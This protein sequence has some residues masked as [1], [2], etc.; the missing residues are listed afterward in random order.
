VGDV[1]EDHRAA[2]AV[3]VAALETVPRV[4]AGHEN[5]R[6]PRRKGVVAKCWPARRK[7]RAERGVPRTIGK[8]DQAGELF[9]AEVGVRCSQNPSTSCAYSSR[10]NVSSIARRSCRRSASR[11]RAPGKLRRRRASRETSPCGRVEIASLIVMQFALAET[12]S[13]TGG[14]KERPPVRRRRRRGTRLRANSVGKA[15]SKAAAP[16]RR[17]RSFRQCGAFATQGFE[18]NGGVHRRRPR[19]RRNDDGAER[20]RFS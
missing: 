18:T 10:T 20:R 14:A 9:H 17:R 2:N 5:C 1:V 6:A 7:C 19:V 12:P 3:D 11:Y 4:F 13:S 8:I 15:P 16:R